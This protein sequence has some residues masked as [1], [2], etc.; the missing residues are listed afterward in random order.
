MAYSDI[1]SSDTASMNPKGR[2]EE[3]EYFSNH[4]YCRYNHYFLCNTM[5]MCYP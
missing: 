5:T 1:A 3:M 2:K 4:T